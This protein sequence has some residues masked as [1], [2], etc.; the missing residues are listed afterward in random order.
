[1]FFLSLARELFWEGKGGS[2][3]VALGRPCNYRLPKILVASQRATNLVVATSSAEKPAVIVQ[4]FRFVGRA[5]YGGP[6]GVVS[7]KNELLDGQAGFVHHSP[8]DFAAGVQ[9]CAG[10][11]FSRREFVRPMARDRS[12]KPFANQD[13]VRRR[14][15]DSVGDNRAVLNAPH[16]ARPGALEDYQA[17]SSKLSKS[18]DPRP[19]IIPPAVLICERK[20]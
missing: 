5:P 13:L 1:M 8:A 14:P 17:A 16:R 10:L 2:G 12:G 7:N 3:K 9:Q 15:G 18:A 19:L 4:L 11:L 20:K 6:Q